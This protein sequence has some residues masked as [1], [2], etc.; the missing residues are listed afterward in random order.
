MQF[1]Y[2]HTVQWWHT[3]AKDAVHIQTYSIVVAHC[4]TGCSSYTD[5]QYSG[6]TLQHRMQFI[7][8]HT[9]LW[10]HTAAQDAVHIQTYS[11]VVTHCS[12][13]TAGRSAVH[14]QV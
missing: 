5:I 1:I 3:A 12:T 6:G 10:W 14:Q 7:Y 11:T 2:S 9:V 13:G 4:S 8:R